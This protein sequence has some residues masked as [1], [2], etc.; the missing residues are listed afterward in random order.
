MICW[1]GGFVLFL[2]YFGEIF[3]GFQ[4]IKITEMEWVKKK[5]QKTN[6]TTRVDD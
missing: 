1:Q 2:T 3:I 6:E 4:A 5:K